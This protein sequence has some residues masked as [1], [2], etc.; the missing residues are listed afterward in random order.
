M[1]RICLLDPSIT[2]RDG[3]PPGNLGDLIIR[4]AVVRELTGLLPGF[5]CISIPTQ[6]PLTPDEL[7]LA[8]GSDLLIVGGTNL[9]SS[10]MQQYQQWR[11]RPAEAGRLQRVVLMGAGWWQYQDEPDAYTRSVLLSALSP[12]LG[13]SVRDNY[14]RQK[15]QGIGLTNV[16]NT[17]CP[18]MWRLTP[19]LLRTI[20]T[21]KADDVLLMLTDY[22]K[23]RPVDRQLLDLLSSQYK[24]VYFWPQGS[25]DARYLAEF[26]APV[27]LLDRSLAALE[28]LLQR[29][30]PI[31]YIGTR[32]HGGIKC[33]EHGRRSLVL[34]IDNRATEIAADTALPIVRRNDLDALRSWILGSKPVRLTLDGA[35]VEKWKGE[36]A[37]AL[38]NSARV[39]QAA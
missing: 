9:L 31:D 37:A 21:S 25:S 13:Q 36:L 3:M 14:T 16:I 32:L 30:E 6:M 12:T 38:G 10:H 27:I 19:D 5:D 15:L 23:N 18:T 26:S 4:Q 22:N 1:P 17:G 28:Q 34:G 11:I 7:D 8:V 33:L 24:R 29:P 39:N 2:S 20:P 35:A